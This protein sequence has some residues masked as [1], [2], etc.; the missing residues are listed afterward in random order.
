MAEAYNVALEES[1]G[2][3][4]N[5]SLTSISFRPSALAAICDAAEENGRPKLI[6][7]APWTTNEKGEYVQY[8]MSPKAGAGC[9]MIQLSDTPE[10][11][12]LFLHG[13]FIRA[14]LINSRER[15]MWFRPELLDDAAP[16]MLLRLLAEIKKYLYCGNIKIQYSKQQEDN[17][18]A[19]LSQHYEW[20]YLDSLKNWLLPFAREWSEKDWPLRISM[21][22][23]LLYYTFVRFNC[24]YNDRNKMVLDAKQQEEF[25]RLAGQLLQYVDNGIIYSKGSLQNFNIPRVMK[26]FLLKLKA[27][28]TGKKLETLLHNGD[29]Y[30]WTHGQNEDDKFVVSRSFAVHRQNQRIPEFGWAY[31]NGELLRVAAI[32]SEHVII[33]II[34]YVNGKLEID[35]TLSIGDFLENKDMV[36]LKVVKGRRTYPA[37]RTEVYGLRK[38]FGQTYEHVYQ[39]HVS[40][41]AMTASDS[42]KMYFVITLNGEDHIVQ[43]RTSTVYAHL[44]PDVAGQ[45][46]Q[47]AKEWCLSISGKN[48]LLVSHVSEAVIKKRENAFQRE[49][50]IRSKKDVAAKKML[51]LRKEY[52]NRKEEFAGRRIWITFDKLYKAG[53]NGEYIYHYVA[54]HHPEIE[55]FYLIK[56]DSADYERMKAAGEKLLIFGQQETLLTVLYAEAILTT[57][58][59]VFG[60][61]GFKKDCI[62]YICDLFNPVN[63]CIQHGLTVQNIAN[64]QNR[65]NDNIRLYL[66]AS[67]NEINNLKRPVYGYDDSCSVLRLTGLSRFDGLVDKKK[68]QILIAPTWRRNIASGSSMGN[69]R[70]HNDFFKNSDYYKVYNSLINDEKLIHAAQK[71]G[72]KI[73]YMLHPTIAE[74]KDDFERNAYVQILSVKDNVPYE[75]LLVESDLMITDYSG[76]QF[77]FAYMRKPILYYHPEILP[78]HFEESQ[79]YS[80]Q[81]DAFGPVINNHELL[82]E[83][84]CEYMKNGCRTKQEYIDRADR[85]FAFKDHNNC[86]RIYDA[87]EGYFEEMKEQ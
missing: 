29:I 37:V 49:L 40:V 22:I 51:E 62:P 80:Y 35:G 8:R 13:Y 36:P 76:I 30:L 23:A 11:L 74:Q 20:W 47:F 14:Y 50:E 38:L 41:P 60:F 16:E 73:I 39:F 21:R 17:I 25:Y 59:S 65:L 10:K 64:Y 43:I 6:S 71:Y 55:I 56:E 81:K 82:V 79:Y 53:D 83:Q 57:H 42:E 52:F 9:E 48:A 66:C 67:E 72:Y 86:A 7:L 70:G 15:H 19:F 44:S 3:Y 58:A 32:K 2:R 75:K 27:E 33:S 34:N 78:A 1:T 28:A 61:M 63:I 31:E 68:K 45:Y 84:L 77:D 26:I 18:S 24:N 12:Q 46:W 54:Q 4:I 85:F 87:I 5:F 69:L